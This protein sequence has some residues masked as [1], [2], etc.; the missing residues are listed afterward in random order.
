M[1][2]INS[3]NISYG[4]NLIIEDLSFKVKK[5]EA[6][7]IFGLNGSGKTSFFN[8]IFGQIPFNGEITFEDKILKPNKV[9]FVETD[10][11][12]YPYIKSQEYLDFFHSKNVLALQLA[13][14]FDI[15]L[16]EFVQ[17]LSTGMKKK[18]TIIANV[19]LDKPILLLDEP[20]NGLDWDSLAKMYLLIEKIKK[21]N[22]IVLIS[23]H[24][25]N[26]L[27]SSC[28][29]IIQIDRGSISNIFEKSEFELIRNS[30]NDRLDENLDIN[31]ISL[32]V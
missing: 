1:L 29:K 2:K 22:K 16:N 11:Y 13:N 9:S 17:N 14:L 12:F 10:N 21:A 20:F 7:G 28:D 24:I 3:L 18:L 27:I 8:A 32:K 23:S 4:N 5:G 6:I 31:N 30:L 19:I 26:T 15:P 25:H